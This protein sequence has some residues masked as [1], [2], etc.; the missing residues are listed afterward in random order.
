MGIDPFKKSITKKIG[1]SI[2]AFQQVSSKTFIFIPSFKMLKKK[3]TYTRIVAPNINRINPTNL[4]LSRHRYIFMLYV[5]KNMIRTRFSL[6]VVIITH[7]HMKSK[8]VS[9]IRKISYIVYTYMY[10]YPFA[11]GRNNNSR[12]FF[13]FSV[14]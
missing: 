14:K 11:L 2:C 12:R 9:L 10:I 5:Y 1:E 6:H 4:N 7:W 8:H 3:K 13:S